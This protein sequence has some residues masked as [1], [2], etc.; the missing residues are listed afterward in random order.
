MATIKDVAH[1]AGVSTT[2]VS[3]V[4]NRT[5][6]LIELGHLRIACIAGPS[7][8]TPSA[9]RVLGYHRALAESGLP[10][11]EG[12]IVPGD[13]RYEGGESAMWRLLRLESP[14]TAVFCCNDLMASGQQG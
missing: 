9:D 3:H 1:L 13:F 10:V 5:R 14:P 11:D 4:L 8:L 2:T 12:L 6:F 7:Q